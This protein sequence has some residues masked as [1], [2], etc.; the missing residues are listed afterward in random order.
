MSGQQFKEFTAKI[1]SDIGVV[2][3]WW[4]ELMSGSEHVQLCSEND[5]QNTHHSYILLSDDVC[6][7]T[8]NC[9]QTN[10]KEGYGNT[11]IM[12]IAIINR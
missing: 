11:R 12:H 10:D 7:L 6:T 8:S 9:I 5:K 4:F 2:C 3:L 1:S